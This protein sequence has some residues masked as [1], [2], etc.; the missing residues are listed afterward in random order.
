MSNQISACLQGVNIYDENLVNK[1]GLGCGCDITQ[2]I[3]MGN[4]KTQILDFEL[5]KNVGGIELDAT[6]SRC[7]IS[8]TGEDYAKMTQEINAGLVGKVGFNFLGMAFG[9]NLENSLSTKTNKLDIYEF[10]TTMIVNKMYALNIKPALYN[11]L[12]DFVGLLAWNEINATNES[13]RTDKGKIKKLYEKYG[14]HISTKAFY[15]SFYQ[16]IL[17]REQ[18]EW[19]SSINAQLKIGTE[20]KV[21]IPESGMSVNG[22]YNASITNKDTECYKHSYKEETERRIGGK[23]N[24]KDLN[25]WLSSCT[26]EDS[27]TC[28]LLGYS[29]GLTGDS[30]S[31]LIPLYDLLGDDDSRKYAMKEALD[32]Y[33]QDKGIALK[34]SKMV[35][36][37]AFGKHFKDGNAPEY[38]YQDRN[39]KKLKYFRLNEN[40]FSHVSGITDGKFYFYYSLGHLL[41]VAVV[42]MKFDDASNIDGN[43]ETRGNHADTGVTGDVKN[44]YLCIMTKNAKD[45][46]PETEFVSGFGLEVD[47]K[48]KVISKGTTTGFTWIQNKDCANWYKGLLH[49]DVYCI[50]T[51]DNLNHF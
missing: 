29:L 13:N 34:T 30:D 7:K 6:Q 15:G 18:N 23:V 2:S 46:V 12:K 21:P 25:D 14:T 1:T 31:G 45:N 49:D 16:Y 4:C 5:L 47:D 20:A 41:D 27:S 17:Y 38:L 36:L 43:W 9:W 51:K 44:R 19:E 50:Y 24:I 32:E 8:R 37:D 26:P 39:D 3:G 11:N 28:A 33:I 10:G 35:V 40:I 22:G 48:V 42:D